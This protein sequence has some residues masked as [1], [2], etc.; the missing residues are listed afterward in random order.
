MRS[1]IDVHYYNIFDD[2]FENMTVQQNIDFI[3]TNRSAELNNITSSNANAPL[4]FVGKSS[5]HSP[6]LSL[7]MECLLKFSFF[8]QSFIGQLRFNSLIN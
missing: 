4:T 8:N 5:Y 3:Y 2:V 7:Y 1:V 6:F